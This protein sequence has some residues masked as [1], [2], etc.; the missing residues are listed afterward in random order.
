MHK[1]ARNPQVDR[2]AMR[3]R[4][5]TG[6]PSQ[7]H[8]D[9]L[10][11]SKQIN[12]I[13][14]KV[15]SGHTLWLI[16]THTDRQTPQQGEEKLGSAVLN[17]IKKKFT[18]PKWLKVTVTCDACNYPRTATEMRP[19]SPDVRGTQLKRPPTCSCTV[20]YIY[21]ILYI[22]MTNRYPSFMYPISYT[23]TPRPEGRKRM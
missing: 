8:L 6:I 5:K 20:S 22:Y 14:I 19:S 3:R 15:H 21:T 23:P 10:W 18:S 4:G 17:D 1:Q 16:H 9:Q 13:S 2:S 11:D 7:P 12:D